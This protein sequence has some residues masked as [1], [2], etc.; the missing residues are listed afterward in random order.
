MLAAMVIEKS[1]SLEGGF[2]LLAGD[3]SGGF[4]ESCGSQ[5]VGGV[6][7]PEIAF[8]VGSCWFY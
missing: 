3:W 1:G 2:S 6:I 7:N 4:S 5:A 8:N